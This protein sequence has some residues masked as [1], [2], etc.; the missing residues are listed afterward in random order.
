M[1]E[2]SEPPNHLN[3]KTPDIGKRCA[4]CTDNVL[5]L[6]KDL[7]ESPKSKAAEDGDR[8]VVI[9]IPQVNELA[10]S[11]NNTRY[12]AHDAES[13]WAI[14]RGGRRVTGPAKKAPNG[15]GK[16]VQA[17][18]EHESVLRVIGEGANIWHEPAPEG[19]S[20]DNTDSPGGQGA[21]QTLAGSKTWCVAAPETAKGGRSCVTPAQKQNT[22]DANILGEESQDDICAQEIPDHTVVAGDLG[23]AHKSAQAACVKL[24]DSL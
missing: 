14:N 21:S 2:K 1:P 23:L 9:P 24:V 17:T 13:Q 12:N 15:I 16:Q 20:G 6:T 18:C 3:M 7:Q 8:Q 5:I 19:H 22:H 10:A 4:C 11:G